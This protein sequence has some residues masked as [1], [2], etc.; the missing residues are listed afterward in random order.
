MFRWLPCVLLL[1][2]FTGGLFAQPCPSVAETLSALYARPQ[3]VEDIVA[4]VR[5]R[6]PAHLDSLS[7]VFH[8]RSVYAYGSE[9]SYAGAID[10]ALRAL[11]VQRELYAQAPAIPLGKTLANL[12]LFYRNQGQLRTAEPYLLEAEQVF[13]Q[14]DAYQRLH[15]NREQLVYLWQ[16]NG[17][18]GRA[19]ELLE[20][21][22]TEA[23]AQHNALGE[24][25]VLRLL[26]VQH[27]ETGSY[28]AAL[29]P[30]EASVAAFEAQGQA[31]WALTATM[32]LGR[33][34]FY[35]GHHTEARTLTLKALRGM[36]GEGQAY[37]QIV[38]QNLLG[39][40]ALRAGDAAEA[41]DWLAKA[42]SLAEGSNDPR[43]LALT[44]DNLAELARSQGNHAAA[45]NLSQRAI[46]HLVPGWTYSEETP[47]PTEAQLALSVYPA[48]VFKYLANLAQ[49]LEAAGQVTATREALA[50]ADALADLLRA[51]YGAAVSKLF[52][53][54]E[55]LPVYDRA[56]RLSAL[57][58]D[59]E[60]SFYYLEKSRAILLLEALLRERAG[61]SLP[62][63]LA[64]SLV[65][66]EKRLL[67]G[68]RRL[69]EEELANRPAVE[70][71]VLLL[72]DG[73]EE[74][75][76]SVAERHPQVRELVARPPVVDLAAAR[77]R[78]G[79]AGWDYQL[80]YFLGGDTARVF[81]LSAEGAA[82][83]SLG[84]T[85]EIELAVRAV[86]AYFTA[87]EKIDQDPAG[88]L[89]ASSHAYALLL[90]PLELPAGA[91]V[92][93]LPDGILASLPFVA[94]VEGEAGADLASAAYVLRRHRIGYAQSATV[95]DHQSRPTDLAPATAPQKKWALAF[96]PF[97]PADPAGGA[98]VLPFSAQETAAV[99]QWYP[100]ET[101]LGLAADRDFLLAALAE[102]PLLHLS[103]HA[104]SV[105]EGGLPPRILT[106]SGAL[107]PADI[108]AL[109]LRAE[110]IMLS[111]C[112]SN[113][114]PLAEGEGM[115]GLGRA[116]TAAGARG[117]VASLW[118]L[119]DRTT[120][121]IVGSFYSH[122]AAGERKPTALHRAQLD[123]L[124][125]DDVPGYLK[126]PYYWAGLTYYGNADP[127][128]A[129]A[130]WSNWF[131]LGGVLV[132]LGLSW[133]LAW[134]RLRA[135]SQVLPPDPPK[136]GVRTRSRVPKEGDQG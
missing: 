23:R 132:L 48:D 31:Y 39:L 97:A 98:P 28:P 128:P 73:L 135:R 67:A 25:E 92:L 21:M 116:F 44:T 22:L 76:K 107:Y 88:Y 10:F 49:S 55:A 37:N 66:S 14:L 34:H 125:R 102:Y 130:G 134:L 12:G 57:A 71:S 40:N 11:E 131:W 61:A 126:S 38:Q 6:C 104:Y 45:A 68:Q 64:D 83:I 50:A 112:E 26:G 110:L 82:L 118:A 122:L 62:P 16:A 120:A 8:G 115:L 58:G 43:L 124:E 108:Y 65:L 127:L 2:G 18:F 77:S 36:A 15:N 105:E 19:E 56:I 30:L 46:A 100:T 60:N 20:S 129:P 59:R 78:L 75:R 84:P 113:I 86:L 69:L 103:T 106:A 32:E 117:V 93:I 87:P 7:V 29:A 95:L 27:I 133:W 101:R 3:A 109:R 90:A 1:G 85:A 99:A 123:Y 24:A 136:G 17:D 51:N 35:L 13:R 42:L 121:E 89:L 54:R 5:A 63:A 81:R 41:N 96:A 4:E 72:R 80:T 53:R 94:L 9:G 33:A 111:A 119:N 79:E 52:W 74:L 47:L 91:G 114:G 70:D